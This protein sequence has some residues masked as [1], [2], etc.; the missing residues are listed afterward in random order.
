MNTLAVGAA[1]IC[2][3]H[4]QESVTVLSVVKGVREVSVGRRQTAVVDFTAQEVILGV[5]LAITP[6]DVAVLVLLEAHHYAGAI[7]IFNVVDRFDVHVPAHFTLRVD[8][9]VLRIEVPLQS[10][11]VRVIPNNT[12]CLGVVLHQVVDQIK[13]IAEGGIS[14]IYFG[15]KHGRF[16]RRNAVGGLEN[17]GSI[18]RIRFAEFFLLTI[19]VTRVC[20]FH[21]VDVVW[22]ETEDRN[23]AVGE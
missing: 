20:Y 7:R 23:T 3:G 19:V 15:L 10:T 4:T 1:I 12:G 11:A 8:N 2:R 6:G 21:R 16:Q 13:A 9:G 5:A 18:H 17:S 14:L 22:I